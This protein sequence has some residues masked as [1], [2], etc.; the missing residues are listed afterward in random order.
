MIF[1]FMY[2][3]INRVMRNINKLSIEEY[4]MVRFYKK[5][6]DD[7]IPLYFFNKYGKQIIGLIFYKINKNF[8][9]VP[10]EKGDLFYFVWNGI[11]ITLEKYKKKQ[12]FG[13]VLIKNCYSTTLKEVKKFLK[14]GEMVMN[15]SYSYDQYQQNPHKYYNKNNVTFINSDENLILENLINNACKYIRKYK[16]ETIKK[17][18][19]L[20]SI[21]FSIKEISNKLNLSVY[22][23]NDLLN[24]I[25]KIVEKGN[26]L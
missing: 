22:Y 17:V 12:D 13:G 19:Y 25:E 8:S 4:K 7:S 11:K 15:M 23:I 6:K 2:K 20:K 10:F 5:S 16:H 14:N 26:W 9:S 24:L 21:G 1:L 3:R 18:I